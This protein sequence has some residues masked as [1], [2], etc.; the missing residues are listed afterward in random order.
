MGAQAGIVGVS[1]ATGQLGGRIVH[2]L[3]QAGAPLR[4][5]V[6]DRAKLRGPDGAE[7][8]Q[9]SYE[10][11]PAMR[12]ALAG[13]HTFVM[14]SAGEAP[15]R[16]A[17]HRSAVD[18]AVAAGVERIVYTSFVAAAPE[19]TFTFGRDHWHTEEYIR[20][21]GL[22]Y[23]F[24]RDNI[25][26]DMFPVFAG[27]D[28]VI[29]GPGGDGRLGAVTRD[30]VADV[31]TVVALDAASTY[32]GQGLDLTGPETLSLS[33]VATELTRV[34]GRP[35]SYV[36]ET[37]EEAYASRASYGAPD[38]EVAGWVTS[39]TAVAAGDL[40]VVS[41]AVPDVTGHPATNF[42]QYLQANPSVYAHLRAT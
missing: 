7:V 6:R 23:T 38:W 5:V 41:S 28:G 16:V 9:A 25:Y 33:E 24:L 27:A 13:V 21:S 40:D 3:A 22:R 26:Q 20:A 37:V 39:Y 31:A 17:L 12:A 30:D 29:R 15:D 34:S 19:T 4:V 2:R 11:G 42:S 8:A 18:A 1:A 35:I 10:D 14:I 36:A 32:D